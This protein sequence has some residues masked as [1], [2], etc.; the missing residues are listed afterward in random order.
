MFYISG[1][2]A[3]QVAQAAELCADSIGEESYAHAAGLIWFA[4][5]ADPNSAKLV[6]VDDIANVL[7]HAT[8]VEASVEITKDPIFLNIA[9]KLPWFTTLERQ[10]KS[11]GMLS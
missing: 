4:N 2:R 3:R 5:P 8:S 9:D 6:T 7:G 10:Q 11:K 1:L